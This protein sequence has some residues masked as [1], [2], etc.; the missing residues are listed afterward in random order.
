MLSP[1]QEARI[2]SGLAECL[3]ECRSTDRPYTRISAFIAELQ[4]DPDW[5][6]AEIIELQTRVIRV[7]LYRHG[8][9]VEGIGLHST[10][11]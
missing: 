6:S 5:T 8:R 1:E 2:E 11:T 3:N 10:T 9:P 4:C 7:L